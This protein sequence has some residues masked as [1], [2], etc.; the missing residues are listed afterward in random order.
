ME[1]E[2]LKLMIES[3]PQGVGLIIIVYFANRFFSWLAPLAELYIKAQMQ[4]GETSTRTLAEMNEL[5]RSVDIRLAQLEVHIVGLDPD[6][7]IRVRPKK[8]V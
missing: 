4:W 2:L 3:W 6:Q 1:T 7:T 5:M 8:T